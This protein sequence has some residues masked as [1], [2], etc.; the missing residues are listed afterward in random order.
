MTYFTQY[1]SRNDN[2][3]L[4][5]LVAF[6]LIST[7]AFG[8]RNIT[9]KVSDS[10]G[11]GLIGANVLVLGT[12]VGTTTDIS[13]NFNLNVATDVTTLEIS[14]TGYK[15]QNVDITGKNSIEITLMENSELLGEVVVVGYGRQKKSVV[16]AAISSINV[17]DIEN[18]ST[19]QLQSAIQGKIAGVT[20]IPSSGSPGAGIKVRIRGVGSNGNSDPLYIVDG[21]RTRD[22]AFLEAQEIA[23]FEVLKD[24]AASAIY[25]AEGANGIVIITTKRGGAGKSRIT[26]SNQFG[27]Q[28]FR[29]DLKLMTAQQHAQYMEEAGIGGRT[30]A[31]VTNNTD[32]VD[33]LFESAPLQKHNISFSGG[34]DKTGYFI[35]GSY[36]DQQGI[37]AGDEDRFKRYSVRANANSQ[38]RDWLGFDFSLNYTH[39]NTK[40]ITEDSEFGGILSNMI[41]MDPITPVT[42]APG[43]E[44]DFAKELI[45]NGSPLLQNENGSYYGLSNFVTGEI[46]NPIAGIALLNGGGSTIDRIMGTMAANIKLA[47]GLGFTSRIGV[48]NTFNTFHNW[49]PSFYFTDTRQSGD[50]NVIQVQSRGTNLL[51]ENFLTYEKRFGVHGINAVAGGSIFNS[52][53]SFVQGAG[54]G[55]IVESNQFGYLSSVQPGPTFTT[56]NGGEGEQ[57]LASYF[58]RLSYDFD[59]KYLLSLTLRRDGSSLLADGQKWGTFPSVSAGWVVSREDFFPQD[60]PLNFLKL[61]ASWGQNGSL[62]NL[63]P[64]AWR[65]AIGFN[66]AYPDGNGVLAVAA[67]PTILSNP[68][69]TWETSEQIDIGADLGFFNDRLSVTFDY[70]NKETKDLLNPGIIPALVGNTAP[71]VNLGNVT[72]KGFEIEIDYKN[73]IGDLGYRVAA[74][75]TRIKNKVTKLD[76]NLDFAPGVGVGTGW[77]ASAFEEG[78]PAWHFRGYKTDGILGTQAEVDAFNEALGQEAQLGDPNVIDV[79][80]DGTLSPDDQTFIG[81]P[82]P[83]ALYGF[84][85]GLD[86]KGFDFSMYLQG[87]VG[88]DILLGYNRT[89]RATSNKPDFYFNDRWTADNP[90]ADWFRANGDNIYAYNSDFMVF[91]GTYMRIKQI[92]L[93]YTLPETV[94]YLKDTRLYIS[95]DDFFTFTKYPGLDPEAGSNNDQSIGIDRGVYPVPGKVLFGLSV[96]F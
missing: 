52:K 13:G 42:Y 96:S 54:T 37:V 36:L 40:G 35:M 88:N 8:Q 81:S 82:H 63:T 68:E 72:N 92:Q 7:F 27:N 77:T 95:I 64:G 43:S 60:G 51:W 1:F 25:G 65:S 15:S 50:A 74:N 31:D 4:M 19:T 86:Y 73:R 44:P 21:M 91:D 85:F 34:N 30:A 59:E 38:V 70:F 62:A 58:G 61:R 83:D 23:T 75:Y 69:L 28:S 16:T 14:Y 49:T 2:R 48:D 93:G 79:N 9:G 53:N 45:T 78:L 89:D 29:S 80:E 57:H 87:S 26:Y 66:N 6:I 32:W 41:L 5:G 17:E 67:E 33:E 90:N 12:S 11:E 20:I 46:F 71:T 47:D 55:L 18:T 22:I 39:S 10:N 84:S 3:K 24:A 76:D 56:A 94:K